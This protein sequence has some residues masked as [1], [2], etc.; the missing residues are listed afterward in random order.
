MHLRH[1]GHRTEIENKSTE[2]GEHFSSCG[3]NNLS[4]QIIDCVRDGEDEAL[5]I[6]E[7][8]WQNLLATFK[9]NDGNINVRNE[10]G[11][12]LGQQPILF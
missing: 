8:Y 10:W 6:L 11:N 12:Y 9:A 7:G 4:L 3:L 2:L 1:G 5:S